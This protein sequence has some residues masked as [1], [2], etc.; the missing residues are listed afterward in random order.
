[1]LLCIALILFTADTVSLK[2]RAADTS[3]EPALIIANSK[4]WKPFSYLEDGQPKG[5]LIDFWRQYSLVSG[6]KVKFVL[7]DWQASLDAVS[8][9]RAAVHAGLLYSDKRAE[10]F[11]F[12]ADIFNLQTSIYIKVSLLGLIEK[13][14]NKLQ[15]AVGVVQGGYEQ[16]FVS[17]NYPKIK[18]VA[19]INN[20]LMFDAVRGG[21]ITAFVAD[22]Q[23]ANFYMAGQ[24]AGSNNYAPYAFL[25]DKAIQFAVK[26]GNQKLLADLNLNVKKINE[27]DLNLIRQK[28]INTETIVPLWF[29]RSLILGLFLLV[30]PYIYI[31]RKT[32]AN[33]TRSLAEANQK[34]LAQVNTDTLTG[35][36]SRRF[37]MDKLTRLTQPSKQKDF[38]LLMLD[39]DYFKKINDTY[40]HLVGDQV[41]SIISKR[42]TSCIR[43]QDTLAR[44][45]G[46]EFCLILQGVCEQKAV[47]ICAKINK[48]IAENPIKHQSAVLTVTISIGCTLVKSGADLEPLSLLQHAD[49]LLYQAKNNGRDQAVIC[50]YLQ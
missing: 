4:A 31:L 21:E 49:T 26:K 42:I 6:R 30:L 10:L 35:L 37:L 43:H 27:Q 34:L 2:L 39:I 25:Y 13:D 24:S 14:L 40:G 50:T 38:A 28:W 19:Y 18:L 11:D 29:Y 36:Y 8:D 7:L 46:E 9:N 17:N 5:L 32:V 47:E 1:M 23:V 12:G 15:Q 41:L 48:K 33:R 16:E 20:Q 44:I 3:A 22:M 45:G